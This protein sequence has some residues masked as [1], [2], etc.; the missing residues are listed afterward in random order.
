MQL[1]IA[2]APAGLA[3]P[4]RINFDCF[5]SESEMSKQNCPPLD[6]V[7]EREK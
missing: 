3:V 5:H 4:Q 6:A 2:S 7:N 1:R